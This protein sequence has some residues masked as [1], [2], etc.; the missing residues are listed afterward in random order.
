MARIT[1]PLDPIPGFEF[2]GLPVLVPVDL[3]HDAGHLCVIVGENAIGTPVPSVPLERGAMLCVIPANA[4]AQI[5]PM[6]KAGIAAM[7][8]GNRIV[9]TNG[10]L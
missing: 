4:A 2:H 5:R 1:G 9:G 6:L 3:E 10:A 8:K 7:N